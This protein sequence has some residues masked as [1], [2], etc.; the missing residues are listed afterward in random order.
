[1]L[2][3]RI[4]GTLDWY[5]KISKDLLM[6]QK[7][8]LE[9]GASNG[10]MWSNIGK[11][12]N[13]G[14]EALVKFVPVQTKDW[15]WDVTL[16][17]AKNKNEILELQNGK[18]DMRAEKWFIG[19]PIDVI[20]DLNMT[21]ICTQEYANEVITVGDVTGTRSEI[22]SWFEGCMTFEDL[23]QDGQINDADRQIIGQ[24]LPKWTGNLSTSLQYKNWDFS[25]AVTTKQGHKLNSPFMDEFTD[26]SDRGRTKLS[27]DFYIPQGAPIFNYTWDGK[28]YGSL[29]SDPTVVTKET[30]VG[31]YPYPMNFEG[32]NHGGTTGWRTGK[33]TLYNPNGVVD[34]SYVKVKNITVGYTFDKQLLS[35][36]HVQSLRV[37]ANV[38]NP[39]IF[40]NYKGFDPE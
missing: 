3:S 4:S 39:F 18:E 35:K 6:K 25:I 32:I 21:G 16:S 17:F 27:M 9:Q 23:N 14:I 33:T 15:Y 7:L 8:L 12:R 34:A 30:I 36:I 38:L 29:T 5:N 11:V 2:G 31:S 19:K 24:E 37:Y 22:Y 13:R 40:T 26:Y 28:D 1:M 10:D 20:Y